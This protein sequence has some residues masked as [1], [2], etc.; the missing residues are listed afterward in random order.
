MFTIQEKGKKFHGH[1][2]LPEFEAILGHKSAHSLATGPV[3]VDPARKGKVYTCVC[4]YDG[5]VQQ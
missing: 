2:M 1:A 5:I 3:T 4:V